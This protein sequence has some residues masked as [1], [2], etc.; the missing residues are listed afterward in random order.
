MLCPCDGKA[1]HNAKHKQEDEMGADFSGK[2]AIVT[3]AGSGIGLA[4][5]AAF[6][7]AGARVVIAEISA[8]TGEQAAQSLRDQG[9][10]A[11]FVQTDVASASSV[12]T[13]VSQTM[14]A[15]G[16]LDYA[17]NNAGIDPE[18]TSEAS[19]DEAVFDRIIAIN[20]KGVF[21]CM[22]YEIAEMLKSGGGAIVNVAS[23]AGI[24]GVANKP[25][26]TASKHAIVGLT[27]ASSLQYARRG[28]RINVLCPGGVDTPIADDNHRG[29]PAFIAAMNNAH[30]IGHIA[31]PSEIA[32][33]A[34]FLCSDAASFMT[35]Q[36]LVLDGGL[37]AG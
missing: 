4:T 3:G 20:L 34:L 31:A 12:E 32:S 17:I 1:Y 24:S 14:S 18:L 30:P 25:S 27:R 26:Y 10:E 8:R 2:V 13:L 21:L 28:I 19:W 9:G 22:K 6:A 5:A 11:I 33:G 37:T 7:Q 15:F 29:D 35:G 16:R 36:P 23:I